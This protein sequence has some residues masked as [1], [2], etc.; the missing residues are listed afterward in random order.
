MN[1]QKLAIEYVAIGS[2]KLNRRNPRIH[3]DK[4]VR[5]LAK[6]VET[7]GFNVP[8]VVD[9]HLQVIAGHGR[10]LYIRA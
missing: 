3:S 4:Q 9:A 10:V 1:H 6:S 7:F 2:L 5:Q 8:V